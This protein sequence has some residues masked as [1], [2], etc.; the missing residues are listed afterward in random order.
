MECS[1]M[2][3]CGQGYKLAKSIFKKLYLTCPSLVPRLSPRPDEIEKE[4]ES[5]G[6]IR[7]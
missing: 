7:T 4:G 3:G 2:S 5:L 6:P 1:L